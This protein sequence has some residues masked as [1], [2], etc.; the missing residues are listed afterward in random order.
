MTWPSEPS[1]P[2]GPMTDR[3]LTGVPDIRDPQLAGAL[4]ELTTRLVDGTDATTV[5]RSVTDTGAALL[6]AAA[7]G[8]MV[9]DPRGGIEVV[10]A[11]DRPARFVE[12]LQTQ[13]AQGPC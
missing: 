6:R 9:L 8:V 7:T 10:A 3:M 11:S 5:L 13:T 1:R 4:V 2:G 12:V